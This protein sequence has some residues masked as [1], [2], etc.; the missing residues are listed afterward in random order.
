MEREWRGNEVWGGRIKRKGG[1]EER[2]GER[3]EG[4][5]EGR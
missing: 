4:G 3:G 2:G 1:G 5:G